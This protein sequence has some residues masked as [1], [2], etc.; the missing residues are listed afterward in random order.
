MAK[1]PAAQQPSRPH[2]STEACLVLV[3]S[4]RAPVNGHASFSCRMP[5]VHKEEVGKPHPY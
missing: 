2:D 5:F 3:F 1:V 4:Q